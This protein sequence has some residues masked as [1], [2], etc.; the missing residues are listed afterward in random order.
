MK[1]AVLVAVISIVIFSFSF[2]TGFGKDEKDKNPLAANPDII[3]YFPLKVGNSWTMED[4]INNGFEISTVVKENVEFEGIKN[5]FEVKVEG[6]DIDGNT[7]YSIYDYQKK[8]KDYSVSL[9]GSKYKDDEEWVN[10]KANYCIL[11]YPIEI[12]KEW[13][14]EED[15]GDISKSK[16][17]ATN[18]KV[19]APAGV[20]KNCLKIEL[21]NNGVF[22]GFEWYAPNVGVVKITDEDGTTILELKEYQI[23]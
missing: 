12:G 8:D 10:E 11:K 1:K 18:E 20:F 9:M 5:C 17:V 23:K 6:K 4:K 16:I 2:S 13:I 7:T 14:A 3:D 21:R 22:N 19:I 15:E